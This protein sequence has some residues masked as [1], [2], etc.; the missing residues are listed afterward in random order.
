[1]PPSAYISSVK[2]GSAAK[3]QSIPQIPRRP[4]GNLTIGDGVAAFSVAGATVGCTVPQ[5]LHRP[6]PPFERRLLC[7]SPSSS[8]PLSSMVA[9]ALSSATP[10]SS[11]LTPQPPP[12]LWLPRRR[13]DDL[14]PLQCC[15]QHYPPALR[16]AW[17]HRRR[18][19]HRR[20]RRR[21]PQRLHGHRAR[22][23]RL[24]R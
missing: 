3:G 1:M 13:E 4:L 22:L 2:K 20:P 19:P 18:G 10:S 7:A 14:L 15:F 8:C 12:H 16:R 6:H 17:T 21:L 24:R 23:V 5:G 11:P 9:A